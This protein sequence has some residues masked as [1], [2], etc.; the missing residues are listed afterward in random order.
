MFK[1]L[2]EIMQKKIILVIA[3]TLLIIV[4]G[5]V[6]SWVLTRSS[7]PLGAV[8]SELLP[9]NSQPGETTKVLVADKTYSNEEYGF[10][11]KYSSTWQPSEVDFPNVIAKFAPVEANEEN[12]DHILIQVESGN[13]TSSIESVKQRKVADIENLINSNILYSDETV[14]GVDSLPAYEIIFEAEIGNFLTKN[15]LIFTVQNSKAYVFSYN[16]GVTGFEKNLEIVQNMVNSFLFGVSE[17]TITV[18]GVEK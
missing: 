5:V 15:M 7:N 1:W 12:L 18:G 11:L 2:L 8:P 9:P 10:S 3:G 13:Y 17:P 16:T 4:V 14:V 6:I